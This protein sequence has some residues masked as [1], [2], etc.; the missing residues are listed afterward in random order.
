MADA[1]DGNE[2]LGVGGVVLFDVAAEAD[3]E[4]VVAPS[5]G[6]LMDAPDLLRGFVCERRSG[7]RVR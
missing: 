4:V 2:V 6:V 3:D 5:V 1:A 7:P